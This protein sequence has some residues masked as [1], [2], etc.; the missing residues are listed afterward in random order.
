MGV[1]ASVNTTMT[2]I[3]KSITQSLVQSVNASA[4]AYCNVEIGSIS[5]T[6]NTGCSITVSNMC[7]AS[8]SG[9]ISA[10]LDAVYETFNQLTVADQQ[11][12]AQMFSATFGV[13]STVSTVKTNFS[14]YVTQQCG[15][16]SSLNQNIKIQNI[17]LGEC[18]PPPNSPLA[19]TFINTGK[20]DANCVI[21]II[22]KLAISASNTLAV[23]NSQTSSNGIIII[24]IVCIVGILAAL[25]YLKA[26]KHIMFTSTRDKIRLKMA[27][28]DDVPWPLYWEMM[29]GKA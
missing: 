24:G 19:L 12:C 11:S 14:N 16:N 7:S 8:S 18:T 25:A 27:S 3:S 2:D 6:K 20:A 26:I 10:V 1:S 15:A 29:T 21:G 5:F 9:Q 23:S 17:T 13:N 22:Q 4:T 28:K